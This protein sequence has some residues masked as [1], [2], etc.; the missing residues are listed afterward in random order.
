MLSNRHK[1]YMFVL[2]EVEAFEYYELLG[3]RYGH[4]SVVT[5]VI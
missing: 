5:Q 3:M 1:Y 4:T 2:Q